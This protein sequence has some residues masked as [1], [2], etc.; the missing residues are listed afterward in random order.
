MMFLR[1]WRFITIIL[2]ALTIAQSAIKAAVAE[3]LHN[4]IS[5][6]RESLN[7]S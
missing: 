2:A 6:K 7:L 5:Q 4:I 3:D 1:I